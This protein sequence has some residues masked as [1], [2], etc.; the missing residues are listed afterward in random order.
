MFG[1]PASRWKAPVSDRVRRNPVELT[2]SRSGDRRDSPWATADRPPIQVAILSCTYGGGHHRVAEVLAH[3]L[4]RLHGCDVRVYDYID[5]F[6]GHLYNIVSTFFYVGSVRWAPWMWRSFYRATSDIPYDGLTQRLVNGLGKGRLAR[7]LQAH[8]PDLVVCT[9]SVPSGTISELKSEKR[10]EVPCVTVVTDHTVHSQW[11]HPHIDLY[12]V[13][14]DYVREGTIARGIPPE[15]VLVTGIPIDPKFGATLERG[16]LQRKHG[17]NPAQPVIL[18]MV[19]AANL[20]RGALD[21]YRTLTE[22]PRSAQILFVCGNDERLRRSVENL[23]PT[24][25]NPVQ[26]FG[27]TRDVDE[28]MAMSDLMVTKA[29]GVTTSEAL[30]AELPMVLVSPVPGQEEENVLYL[31]QLGAAVEATTLAD[32][33]RTILDLLAHPDRLERMRAAARLV[34]RPNAAATAIEA[35]LSLVSGAKALAVERHEVRLSQAQI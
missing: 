20:V 21:V 29:G 24:A 19:G 31:T 33:R 18:A 6:I 13:S 27:Y 5:A 15:H 12:L 16:A 2:G 7:F 34:K 32:L 1:S 30:A 25:Q 26:V 9:Y 23:A 4:R 10:T 28:L 35:M 22:L 8:Q 3:E 11:I 14:T 17:L